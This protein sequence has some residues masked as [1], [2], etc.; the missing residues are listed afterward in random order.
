MKALKMKK[1]NEVI[2]IKKYKNK[3]RNQE[4]QRIIIPNPH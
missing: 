1:H 4:I 2:N 3:N